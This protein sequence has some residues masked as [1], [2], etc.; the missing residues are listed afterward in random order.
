MYDVTVSPDRSLSLYRY[1]RWHGAHMKWWYADCR[2][3][4]IL[5]D[6]QWL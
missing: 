1:A 3:A 4:M 2:K 6:E 5:C